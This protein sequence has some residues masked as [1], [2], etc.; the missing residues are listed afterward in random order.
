MAS[1]I[2]VITRLPRSTNRR[3][4]AR[5]FLSEIPEP[6][7]RSIY[8][9]DSGGVE[10][11]RWFKHS[12]EKTCCTKFIDSFQSLKTSKHD[13][14]SVHCSGGKVGRLRSGLAGPFRVHAAFYSYPSVSRLIKSRPVVLIRHTP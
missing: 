10:G 14:L 5:T 4:I 11:A 12:I 2:S 1:T 9:S 6:G 3:L 8:R 7:V 13:I